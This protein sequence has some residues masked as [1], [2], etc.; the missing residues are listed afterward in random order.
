MPPAT[1][2]N[3]RANRQRCSSFLQFEDHQW[4][5][6]AGMRSTWLPCNSSTTDPL[7]VVNDRDREQREHSRPVMPRRELAGVAK[8]SSPR[9]SQCRLT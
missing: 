9:D 8:G 2:F 6:A 4:R 3:T 7:A 5:P 1:S